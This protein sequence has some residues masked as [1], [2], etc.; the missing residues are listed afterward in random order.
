[1]SRIRIRIPRS[2]TPKT[3]SVA[4]SAELLRARAC[5]EAPLRSA[6][7]LCLAAPLCLAACFFPRP[8]S[9]Q[10]ALSESDVVRLALARAPASIVADATVGLADARE[11]TAGLLPNPRVSWQREGLLTG[12]GSAQDVFRASVPI[13]VARPL[14]ARSLAASRSAWLRSQASLARTAAVLEAVLVY[15][16]VVAAERR[17]EILGRAVAS[18]DEA[19]RV[20]VRRE[21]VGTA[22][23]YESS[24]LAIA[25]EL[26]RSRLAELRGALRGARARLGLLL[27]LDAATFRVDGALTPSHLPAEAAL[28]RTGT[29]TRDVAQHARA[30]TVAAAEAE[31]R[32]EWAWLPTFTLSG[33]A[34]VVSDLG[35]SYGY[36]VG[37]SL[38]IPIFDHGQALR[39]EAR[40]QRALATARSE[41]LTRRVRGDVAT[42]HAIYAAAVRE[43]GRF[44][45][46][47]SA[48]VEALHSAAESGYREGE[49]TIV[50]LLDAQRARTRVAERRL[51][52][53]VLAKR[54]EARLRA[55]GG[56]L[57]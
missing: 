45:A 6:A 21:E 3:P 34:N 15:Y 10:D 50:E 1:M 17:V 33:G 47:T 37:L 12:Q 28:V 51:D 56:E 24:R 25:S 53:L 41:A 11:Q 38:S 27:D 23:G 32:A 22:S 54:A 8:A 7:L 46:A 30:S 19:A 52:L 2:A 35:T 14:S 42:A 16:G 5:L 48:Q 49:R 39:S 43:L 57:R 55:A 4:R 31:S 26:A 40:A 44:D 18:L 9:S 36:V 29:T 20:L 13:D